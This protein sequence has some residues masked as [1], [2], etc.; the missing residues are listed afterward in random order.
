MGAMEGLSYDD[1]VERL[2]ELNWPTLKACWMI[3]PAI[4]V[5]TTCERKKA[6][7]AVKGI[8]QPGCSLAYGAVQ[9][10]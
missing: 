9:L 6:S 1:T 5:S 7:R 10:L 3:W 2:K 8:C 4:M